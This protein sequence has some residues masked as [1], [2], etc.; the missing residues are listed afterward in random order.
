MNTM[1]KK[2]SSVFLAVLLIVGYIRTE[3]YAYKYN[4]YTI[5][6]PLS[7]PIYCSSTTYANKINTYARKWNQCPEVYLYVGNSATAYISSTVSSVSNGYYAITYNYTD[8]NHGIIFYNSWVNAS[9]ALKNEIIVHEFGHALGLAHTQTS[10]YSI[11][12]MRAS[13]YD[14]RSAVPL[15]DDKA[16]IAAKY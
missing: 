13:G 11:S 5:S 8:D 16:G 1:L 3:A 15:A 10:N 2:I 4:G 9:N 6:T 12:V 7:I 14:G